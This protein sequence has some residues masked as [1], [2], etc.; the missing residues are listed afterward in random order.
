M[1]GVDFRKLLRVPRFDATIELVDDAAEP[2]PPPEPESPET[3]PSAPVSSRRRAW[4]TLK[5]A[6]PALIAVAA[7]LALVLG[8]TQ[9]QPPAPQHVKSPVVTSVTLSQEAGEVA[10]WADE[11]A[12]PPFD[13]LVV[14]NLASSP[15]SE[16]KVQVS[17][18]VTGGYLK[19]PIYTQLVLALPGSI[20]SCTVGTVNIAAAA[21]AA[22]PK[23]A[24]VTTWRIIRSRSFNVSPSAL[25]FRFTN[26]TYWRD[27]GAGALS[28]ISAHAAIAGFRPAGSVRVTAGFQPASECI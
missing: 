24:G 4:G 16:V 8:L 28:Q 23:P 14:E 19:K 21:I 27:R 13:P 2:G 25:I 26:G 15:V 20:P 5:V 9:G 11:L 10:F 18:D 3:E 1:G 17:I 12:A 7:V 6:A 22:M